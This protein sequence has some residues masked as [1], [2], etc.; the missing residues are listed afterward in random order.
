VKRAAWRGEG[1]LDRDDINCLDCTFCGAWFPSFE[2]LAGHVARCHDPLKVK[3][4]KAERP[5]GG[6]MAKRSK[7]QATPQ[8]KKRSSNGALPPPDSEQSGDLPPFIKADDIGDVGDEATLTLLGADVRIDD[9]N[10]GEQAIVPIKYRNRPYAWAIK[11]A[12]PSYRMLHDRFG[13]N[14]KRWKGPVAVQIKE[15]LGKAYIAVERERR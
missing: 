6:D 5:L 15:W 8:G 7:R 11:T 13:S 2:R 12:S 10:Y 14:P 3:R 9:G 4:P 1:A